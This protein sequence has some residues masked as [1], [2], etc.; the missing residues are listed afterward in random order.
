MYNDTS[1]IHLYMHAVLTSGIPVDPNGIAFCLSFIRATLAER[2][3]ED[4]P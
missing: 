1:T 3:A 4:G 2:V